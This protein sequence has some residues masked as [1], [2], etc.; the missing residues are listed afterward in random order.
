MPAER[1][2]NLLE[3]NLLEIE[4]DLGA[5]FAQCF[6]DLEF[7][8]AVGLVL[9]CLQQAAMHRLQNQRH[10]DENRGIEFLHVAQGIFE[11]LAERDLRAAVRC[12]EQDDR[13]LV[14]VVERQNRQT[15]VLRVDMHDL[16]RV[17]HILAEI[18]LAEHHAL[19]SA[20]RAGCKQEGAQRFRIDLGMQIVFLA[21]GKQTPA[22][23]Q[24]SVERQH[25]VCVFFLLKA[26]ERNA[27]ELF[28]INLF[29]CLA[30][31]EQQ[32]DLGFFQN[33]VYI[34]R[35]EFTVGRHNDAAAA[36]DG[37]V[38]QTPFIAVC[39]RNRNARSGQ[40]HFK[41]SCAERI[42]FVAVFAVCDEIMLAVFTFDF[43]SVA[44]AEQL[45]AHIH[46]LP[47][48]GKRT[49]FI[50]R[51]CHF[52]ALSSHFAKTLHSDYYIKSVSFRQA[53][54]CKKRAVFF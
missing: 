40:T 37:H 20:C 22:L 25:A 46:Q 14:C 2:L 7:C 48:V 52:Q 11:S 13:A 44:I 4:S 53:V 9:D 30:V 10:A 38:R 6:A 21:A 31:A 35:A 45:H 24:Q 36:H 16:H 28:L 23:A 26:D 51:L 27:G 15:A 43:K 3:E 12:A 34:L 19:G 39:G 47:Q 1:L 5:G 29:E 41:Q 49:N 18:A 17:Q 54:F 32:L 8:L 33:T 42:D 50:K